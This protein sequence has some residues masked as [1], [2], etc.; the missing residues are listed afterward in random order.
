[1]AFQVGS[2]VADITPRSPCHLAGYGARDHAHEGVH[3]QLSVRG[4]YVRT[5]Q[6]EAL[7]FSADILWYSGQMIARIA[8]ALEGRLNIPP[9]HVQFCG[10]HT[11]SAPDVNNAISTRGWASSA[12]CGSRV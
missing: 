11:H 6:G 12:R 4:F 10:T 8:S 5:D 1:M 3:D 2:G 9:L 7:V